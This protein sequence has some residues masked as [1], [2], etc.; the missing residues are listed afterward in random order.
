MVK[1]TFGFLLLCLGLFLSFGDLFLALWSWQAHGKPDIMARGSFLLAILS[2][3]FAVA[4]AV[5]VVG[6]A[7][8]VS[9]RRNGRPLLVTFIA[10]AAVSIT[11]AALY[12]DTT[13]SVWRILGTVRLA[14]GSFGYIALDALLLIGGAW[15]VVAGHRKGQAVHAAV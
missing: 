10:L 14:M 2:P 3:Y 11:Y 8:V 13:A 1:T 15:L 9:I 12:V 4:V 7:V 6:A 5:V